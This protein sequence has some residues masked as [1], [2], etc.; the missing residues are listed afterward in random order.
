MAVPVLPTVLLLGACLFWLWLWAGILYFS[1]L[2]FFQSES[3]LLFKS[4]RR[5]QN[6]FGWVRKGENGSFHE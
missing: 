3:K 5:N 1:P 4:L 6:S 2:P